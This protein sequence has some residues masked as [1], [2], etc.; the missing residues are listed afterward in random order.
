M[1]AL[2]FGLIAQGKTE[3]RNYLHSP[4]TDAMA[5][6]C[7][8]FGAKVDIKP[9]AIVIEGKFER[10]EDVIQA[11]NSGQ[12]LRFIGAISALLPHYTV[13]T[14][15]YSIRHLRPIKP[16]LEGLAQ[17]GAFA[18][19]MRGDGYA[20]MLVK[21]PIHGGTAL[22]SGED[23][24]PVSGLLMAAAFAQ[25]KSEI[26]VQNPGE[27]P[28][29]ALTLDWFDR[30]G[31]AYKNENFEKYTLPGG[32]HIEGFSYTVPS[33][34]SSAAYPI[35]AALI[36]DSEVVLKDIDLEDSQGDKNLIFEL[37][38]MGALID[39]DSTAKTLTVRRG[40]HLKGRKI[41]VNNFI[42]GVTLL[43]VIGCFAEGITE[44]VGAK[45]ARY[46]ES[47]RISAIVHELKKMGAQIHEKED[48]VIVERST[49]QGATL[50]AH[51]DHRLA[52]SLA[53]AGLGAQG[54]TQ[55]EGVDCVAKSYPP[56]FQHLKQ[57][58][59]QLE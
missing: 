28:W 12:V 29:V 59:A 33:D 3:I 15:D 49:L 17:L 26:F 45:I 22:I 2:V 8:A 7:R 9:D 21:G 23:S 50:S 36:T 14:G 11:G 39:V 44:I 43:S 10:S 46:K 57:L 24:Q 41:D 6:A 58:G 25:G 32:A 19:S 30:L 27:I 13:V 38:Q 16:L 18:E 40:S 4:D 55:I 31:I 20:P 53:V 56:F 37:Q 42:D 48:G 35:A 51:A 54:T 1:R 5:Q 52:M 47:D 34:L